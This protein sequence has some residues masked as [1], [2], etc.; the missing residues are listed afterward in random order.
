MILGLPGA[1][2]GAQLGE[3]AGRFTRATQHSGCTVTAGLAGLQPEIP[4]PHEVRWH[5]DITDIVDQQ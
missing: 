5:G 3:K 1:L 2:L 4:V